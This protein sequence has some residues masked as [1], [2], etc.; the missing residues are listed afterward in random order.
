MR[1]HKLTYQEQIEHLKGKGV[2]FSI[3]SESEALT[4]LQ[5]NNNFFKLRAYRK[6]YPKNQDEK[7]INLDFAYLRDLAIID[8]SFRYCL[9]QLCLDVE[10][11]VKIKLISWATLSDEDGYTVVS[12][13][14]ETAEKDVFEA[15]KHARK[16]QYCCAL[17]D[18][19]EQNMPIWAFVEVISF[20]TLISFY[21]FIAQRTTD[22]KM[23]NDYYLLQE[24][25]QIRNASAH[26]NC[27]I[28]DLS[29]KVE[30]FNK[31]NYIVMSALGQAEISK[32]TRETKMGN[33]RIR[34]ITT[35]L[36]FHSIFCSAAVHKYKA[37][38]LKKE[39]SDRMYENIEY[40]TENETI[41]TTFD[42]FKKIIDKWFAI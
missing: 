41:L 12:D 5:E 20:N 18:K 21:R 1:N 36:Y 40:Y 35:L 22:N 37:F 32:Q 31:P 4:Y 7:Y 14:I 38:I 6:N 17:M 33:S 29:S 26:S 28:N 16:S 34:Q 10:H 25:R 11:F 2:R 15:Y 13:F 39:I 8:M 3:A 24:I 23:K 19:Y 42:F 30:P 9:L 27:V